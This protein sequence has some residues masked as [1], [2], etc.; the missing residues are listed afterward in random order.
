MIVSLE[1]SSLSTYNVAVIIF[2]K[3]RKW[4]DVTLDKLIEKIE[5]ANEF[6]DKQEIVDIL[7]LNY[8]QFF[9]NN[10]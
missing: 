5:F 9:E 3:I 6:L 2:G 4:N 1:K 10:N 8:P 7:K